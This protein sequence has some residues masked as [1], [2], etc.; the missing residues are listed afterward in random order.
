MPEACGIEARSTLDK[1]REWIVGMLIAV[2]GQTDECFDL[3]DYRQPRPYR[4]AVGTP[5]AFC[6]K[7]HLHRVLLQAYQ[8]FRERRQAGASARASKPRSTTPKLGRN[9]MCPCGSG[10]KYKKCCGGATVN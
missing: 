9:E 8:Y 5:P 3:A 4:M 2:V 6:R 7:R 1:L 10:K